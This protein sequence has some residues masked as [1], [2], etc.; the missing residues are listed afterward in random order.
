LH[1]DERNEHG[2]NGVDK[3]EYIPCRST[4]RRWLVKIFVRGGMEVAFEP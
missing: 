4:E 2:Q 3:E 1:Y